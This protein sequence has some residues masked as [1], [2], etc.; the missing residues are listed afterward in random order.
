MEWGCGDGINRRTN[1]GPCRISHFWPTDFF[2]RNFR[3]QIFVAGNGPKWPGMVLPGSRGPSLTQ[4]AQPKIASFFPPGPFTRNPILNGRTHKHFT[5]K[6]IRN[7]FAW[8]MTAKIFLS[9]AWKRASLLGNR[10]KPATASQPRQGDCK[11]LPVTCLEAG[12][13][14][15]KVA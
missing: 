12:M 10:P 11:S 5:E 6:P 13:F 15:W 4:R 8:D 2:C 7:K 1:I 3:V 14:A 9:K